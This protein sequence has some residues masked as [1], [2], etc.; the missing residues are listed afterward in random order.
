MKAFLFRIK[1][2][3]GDE[4]GASQLI[5]LAILCGA[6]LTIPVL[7]DFASVHYARRTAQTGV[8]AAVMSA[9]KDYAE[10][11]SIEW[12]GMCGEPPLVVVGRY[13]TTHV[14]PIGWSTMGA[15]SA[16]MYADL[17]RSR[18][19]RYN[20]YFIGDSK[21][22]DGVTINYIQIFGETEKDINVLVEY[23]QEF[24]A[25][26]EATSVVFL[27]RYDRWEF[28]C[29]YGQVWY[30]YRFYWKIRLVN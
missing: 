2:K 28:P 1:Q 7:F 26:A 23:Q 12:A 17:N 18:L 24:D 13:N 22:V 9:A 4:T 19:T 14:I 16:A 10:A 3:V 11:L 21:N 29:G 27:D 15:G 6:L 20:N 8:D 5:V 30:L 25:P